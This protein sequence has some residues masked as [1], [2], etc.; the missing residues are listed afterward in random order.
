MNACLPE[1]TSKSV[2]LQNDH[3]NLDFSRQTTQKMK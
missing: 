1:R 3:L 2:H